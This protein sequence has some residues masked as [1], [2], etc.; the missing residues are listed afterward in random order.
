MIGTSATSLTSGRAAATNDTSWEYGSIHLD[1]L[2]ERAV[3][4]A[5]A[6]GSGEGLIGESVPLALTAAHDMVQSCSCQCCCARLPA[7][8]NVLQSTSHDMLP[9]LASQSHCASCWTAASG[10]PSLRSPGR[11]TSAWF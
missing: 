11:S 10:E 2:K 6:A 1:R 7:L 9:W 4:Y 3:F 5:H 8:L